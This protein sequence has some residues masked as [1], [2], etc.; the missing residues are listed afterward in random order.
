MGRFGRDAAV[1]ALPE[2]AA[3]D[4]FL[5]RVVEECSEGNKYIIVFESTNHNTIRRRT[6]VRE[7]NVRP[8]LIYGFRSVS[9]ETIPDENRETFYQEFF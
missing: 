9:N 5:G 1:A 4:S 2:C 8:I 3:A 6:T 7:F